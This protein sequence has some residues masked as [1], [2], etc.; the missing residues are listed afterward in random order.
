MAVVLASSRPTSS[1]SS[2]S[3]LSTTN[4]EI[5]K[6]ELSF[7]KEKAKLTPEENPVRIKLRENNDVELF[8][9]DNNNELVFCSSFKEA[10][11]KVNEDFQNDMNSNLMKQFQQSRFYKPGYKL[12]YVTADFFNFKS[13]REIYKGSFFYWN[14]P[15]TIAA[16]TE[17]S[18][19]KLANY[20]KGGI[21]NTRRKSKSLKSKKA[22][23][24]TKKAKKTKTRNKKT[25]S[26]NKK[27]QK[28]K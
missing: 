7:I 3:S 9:R 23:A 6:E 11:R 5:T 10:V 26:K 13:E 1:S 22:K 24:K 4:N 18:K 27:K 17:T 16:E 14:I 21:L 12:R 15:V 20:L 19:I 8:L 28:I 2:F 25:K